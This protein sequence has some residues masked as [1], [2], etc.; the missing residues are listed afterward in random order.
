MSQR[1]TKRPKYDVDTS[2]SDREEEEEEVDDDGEEEEEEDLQRL[3]RRAPARSP[4]KGVKQLAAEHDAGPSQPDPSRS[5]CK[6]IIGAPPHA[7]KFSSPCM[8]Q[9]ASSC[10][11]TILLC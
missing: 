4:A 11:L 9:T 2:E 5:A 6:V 7:C 8:L 3:K 1:S 10:L